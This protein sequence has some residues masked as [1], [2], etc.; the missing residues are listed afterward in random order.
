MPDTPGWIRAFTGLT[1]IKWSS[2]SNPRGFHVETL[3]TGGTSTLSGSTSSGPQ[4]PFSIDWVAPVTECVIL[5]LDIDFYMRVGYTA[6][7]GDPAHIPFISIRPL[8]TPWTTAEFSCMVYV[9]GT[10]T[11]IA[12][13]TGTCVRGFASVRFPGEMYVSDPNNVRLR[14]GVMG[15]DVGVPTSKYY[16]LRVTLYWAGVAASSVQH[17]IVDSGTVASTISG[18]PNVNVITAP[19]P[20]Q[21]VIVDSGTVASTISGTPNVNVVTAP[22][23]VQHVIVDSVPS[24]NVSVINTPHVVVDSAPNPVQHVVMDA[25]VVTVNNTDPLP[26]KQSGDFIVT[27]RDGGNV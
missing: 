1:T 24:T 27:T 9:G 12:D 5:G 7:Q 10:P 4:E 16:S 2:F 3:E 8:D 26:V 6:G 21:H 20:V 22:N 15:S 23:P 19:N 13:G 18:T 17:V 11:V 14:V 25:G